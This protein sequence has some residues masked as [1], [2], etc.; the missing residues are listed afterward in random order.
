[1]LLANPH[2][3]DGLA[4]AAASPQSARPDAAAAMRSTEDATDAADTPRDGALSATIVIGEE[5]DTLR[6]TARTV[7]GLLREEGITVGAGDLVAPAPSARLRDGMVVAVGRVSITRET[8]TAT[9]PHGNREVVSER[10]SAG[11]RLHT[12]GVDGELSRVF[13]VTT[14]DGVEVSRRLESERVS[15]APVDEVIQ[16]APAQGAPAAATGASPTGSASDGRGG[17]PAQGNAVWDRLAQCESGQNWSINTGNGYYGGLQFDVA[18]WRAHGGTG[19]PHE[20]SRAEQIAVAERLRAA[21]G[22]APWPACGRTLGL[23]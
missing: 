7:R 3:A 8:T 4:P 20:H 6:T 23:I 19:Y 13:A 5:R 22:F 14:V 11:R 10:L 18:T 21:R 16:V 2:D 12:A 1:M 9:V 15:Q 17:C